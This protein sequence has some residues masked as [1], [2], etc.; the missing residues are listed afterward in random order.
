MSETTADA[1]AAELAAAGVDRVFGLPGGEVLNLLDA[2]RRRGVD[3]TLTRH[4]SAA[5]IAAAVY[6]KLRGTAGVAV[7]TLGPGASNLLYPVANSL[8][9]REPLL[10]VTAQLPRSSPAQHTHQRLPLLD[11]F[12][13]VSKLAAE[14]TP[15]RARATVRDALAAVL[16]EPQGSAYLTLSAEDARA[17]AAGGQASPRT[18]PEP[19]PHDPEAVAAELRRRLAAA[20]KP[21]LLVGIGARWDDSELLRRL[22]ATWGL[23]WGTTPKAKGL[24]DEADPRFVGVFGGMAIDRLML[25]ALD[26]ADLV[27]GFGLDPVEI[28]KTWHATRPIT[29]VLE[30]AGAT[31]V[32]P[33]QALLAGHSAV[34]EALLTDPPPRGWRDAFATVRA[35]RAATYAAGDGA[36]APTGIVAAARAGAP[37]ETLVTT[38]VGS[39]KFLFGQFWPSSAPGRFWMS[40]GLSG[41]GYG[42]P[43]AIGAKL[44]RPDLPVLAVLGDGGFAMSAAELETARRAGAG[45]AVL[46]LADRS[47]SLIRIAQEGRGL[48]NWGVD[49]TPIDSVRV[50]EAAGVEG[51]RVETAEQLTEAVARALARAQ[52]TVIEVPLDADA[53]R[54]LV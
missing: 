52:V 44:A 30:S 23:A 19:E 48:P 12:R 25:S 18:E 2:L 41:M 42:L 37:A 50:A 36:L 6:G 9:D 28:D 29:W 1:V 15:E 35:D 3:F 4:E 33:A 5:G 26:E 54:G 27:V 40:N 10:A 45:I 22:V 13:P 7:A 43:A 46:V 17:P 8:L 16:A 53:Y 39:H 38:D 31:G 47:L 32:T 20:E 11:I 34:L 51:L 14:V 21:L 24:L 49:F